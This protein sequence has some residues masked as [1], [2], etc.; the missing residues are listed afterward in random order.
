ME[1]DPRQVEGSGWD[2]GML[3]IPCM[4]VYITI[5]HVFLFSHTVVIHQS[6][7]CRLFGI[8]LLIYHHLFAL[9]RIF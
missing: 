5:H 4:L 7:A 6:L 2:G 8:A 9:L 3:S 1:G